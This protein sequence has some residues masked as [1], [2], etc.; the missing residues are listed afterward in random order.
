MKYKILKFHFNTAVHFG[1]NNLSNT[2]NTFSSDILFSAICI[3]KAK[4][5]GEALINEML[6]KVKDGKLL[7][8][9]AF[10]YIGDNYFLPKPI[11]HI[12]GKNSESDSGKKKAYKKMSYINIKDFEKFVKGN[13]DNPEETNEILKNFGENDVLTRVSISSD[14]PRPYQVGVYRYKNNAG[15]YVIVAYEDDNVFNDIFAVVENIGISGIG[16][17]K[18]SGLGKF[19]VEVV[20]DKEDI[21][22]IFVDMC[23]KNANKYMTLSI[24]LPQDEEMKETLDDATYTLIRKGGFVD[25]TY[26]NINKI[27]KK[28]IYLFK[29]GSCFKKKYEGGVYNISFDE[30]NKIYKYAKPLWIGV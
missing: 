20:D 1:D 8:S 16:G 6:E 10:P 13:F 4:Q 12:D 19:G 11:M 3:E 2:S 21:Y 7:F 27:K 28:E 25:T 15:L 17:K 24:S 9:D 22:R 29:S 23:N 5:G 14:E 18:T 26:E 30:N